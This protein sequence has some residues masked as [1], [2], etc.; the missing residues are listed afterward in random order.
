ME[1]LLGAEPE[2]S[3]TGLLSWARYSS[4]SWPA[5]GEGRAFTFSAFLGCPFQLRGSGCNENGSFVA[6]VSSGAVLFFLS[7]GFM[8]RTCTN[9]CED[10]QA[11]NIVA[12]SCSS[13]VGCT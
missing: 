5:A 8:V 13:T 7:E 9:H 1:E 2:A 6:V 10:A 3:G 12:P 11:D 4:R